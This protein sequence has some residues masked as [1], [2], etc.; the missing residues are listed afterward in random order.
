MKKK[1]KVTEESEFIPFYK[2][3]TETIIIV[4]MITCSAG[5]GIWRLNNHLKLKTMAD[6]YQKVM[7]KRAYEPCA[8]VDEEG[9]EIETYSEKESEK[10]DSQ[11]GIKSMHIPFLR[12]Y[13]W[14]DGYGAS[15]CIPC[16]KAK[17]QIEINICNDKNS[18]YKISQEFKIDDL[19]KIN[20]SLVAE[21]QGQESNEDIFREQNRV[22]TREMETAQG[23]KTNSV[24]T[25]SKSY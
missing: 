8:F 5:F 24:D 25:T 17:D 10:D 14:S 7:D 3:H 15:N 11:R 19:D 18:Y 12:G 9:V 21:I 23:V 13:S 4:L 22:W 1:L 16:S 6:Q 2:K 20:P